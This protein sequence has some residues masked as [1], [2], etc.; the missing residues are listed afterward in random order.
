VSRKIADIVELVK[1]T[2]GNREQARK[3]VRFSA[4]AK[5]Q[6]TVNSNGF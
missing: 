1:Q 4:G 6:Q 3:A 2:I 5:L